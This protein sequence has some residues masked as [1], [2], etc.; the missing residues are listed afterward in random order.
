LNAEGIASVT[1][2]Q[3]T[4][5]WRE[6]SGT[7]D[8]KARALAIRHTVL[9]A[10]HNDRDF[11]CAARFIIDHAEHETIADPDQVTRIHVPPFAP[12]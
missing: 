3:Y 12:E 11:R 1:D 6:R 9:P 10:F 2:V 8:E 7:D 5:N 4:T